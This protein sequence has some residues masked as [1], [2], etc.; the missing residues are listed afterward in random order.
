M[1]QTR[2]TR[3]ISDI[4]NHPVRVDDKIEQTMYVVII[5]RSNEAPH[6]TFDK[7]FYKRF[8]FQ[9][10]MMEEYKIRELYKRKDRTELVI[11]DVIIGHPATSSQAGILT[12]IKCHV[13]F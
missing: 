11:E 8:N 2:T 13:A 3:R 12:S 6:Q 10:V 1:I 5:P 9:S 4:Q 7:K